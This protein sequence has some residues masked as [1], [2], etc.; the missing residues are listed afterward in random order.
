[1]LDATDQCLR[2]ILYIGDPDMI[3]V[4]NESQLNYHCNEIKQSFEC[5]RRF[6]KCLRLLPK[7]MFTMIAR[8]GKKMIKNRCDK[9]DGRN[10]FLKHSQCFRYPNVYDFNKCVDKSVIQ[11]N[12]INKTAKINEI[13]PALCCAL[14][15]TIKCLRIKGEEH[16]ANY[17]APGA[18]DY[19]ASVTK[20]VMKDFIELSCGKRDTL[21]ECYKIEAKWMKQ[22]DEIG[23]KWHSIKPQRNSF[24]SPLI[25]IAERLE[26]PI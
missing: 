4:K 21:E 23:E 19:V 13:I 25:G 20:S 7:L 10:E 14:Q 15:D 18:G 9:V 17:T 11:M 24:F 2:K 5:I 1:M 3:F 22:F 12:L 26:S 8:G 16:C 6:G